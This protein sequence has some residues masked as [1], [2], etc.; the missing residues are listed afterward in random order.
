VDY[1]HGVRLAPNYHELSPLDA[2]I[3]NFEQQARKYH[4]KKNSFSGAQETPEQRKQREAELQSA[5]KH[6]E[7][8]RRIA[9]V[10]ADVQVKLESYRNQFHSKNSITRLERQNNRS[11]MLGEK[12]HPTEAL[13]KFMRAEG[14]PQP[15][16]KHTA[17][18]IVPGKGKTAFAVQARIN[19]H[20]YD[21]RINDPSNG[22]WLIRLV[23]D[24]G[25]WSMPD[26]KSHLEIHTHN[27]EKWVFSSTKIAM[28]ENSMRASLRRVRLL[29]ESGK[30]PDKVT[31]PPDDSWGGA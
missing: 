19:L 23:V 10:T 4:R 25:H 9:L 12:H 28:D 11:G 21:I 26:S 8:E 7:Q 18:H 20:M 16:P 1:L 15:S 30:Q 17:H 5:L 31:M 24:K 2:A 14:R 22:V 6:L 27:Y 29:L 3:S 13:A